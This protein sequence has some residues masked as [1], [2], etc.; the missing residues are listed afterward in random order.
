MYI[1]WPKGIVGLGI[2][3]KEIMRE[4]CILLGNL[5][6]G[7]FDA[8]LLWPRHLA[9]YL[10]N[11]CKL[12][13]INADSCIFFRKYEKGK[14]EIVMSVHVDDVFMAGKPE[15]LKVIKERSK[16]SSTSQSQES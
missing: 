10:V 8:A 7:N 6:Y 2:I 13:R 9:E 1:E 12:K 3:S 15:T 4:Y 14:L 5:V 11:E 16:K